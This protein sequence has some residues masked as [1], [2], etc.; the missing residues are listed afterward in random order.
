MEP[1]KSPKKR[2]AFFPFFIFILIFLFDLL[3]GMGHV[4]IKELMF[5]REIILIV[6]ML[7]LV[8]YLKQLK[9][10]NSKDILIKI[11]T[12]FFCVLGV[13]IAYLVFPK[14]APDSLDFYT[15]FGPTQQHFLA[16]IASLLFTAFGIIMLLVLRDMI[17]LRRKK[18]THRNFTLLLL[19]LIGYCGYTLVQYYQ[20]DSNRNSIESLARSGI[21]TGFLALLIMF[22][23]INSFRN[24]WI[25]YLNKRQKIRHLLLSLMLVISWPLFIYQIF[26]FEVMA[27]SL[28]F[29]FFTLQVGLFLVIY[30]SMTFI[31]I[32]FHLP[33]AGIV[34]RKIKEIQS[35]HALSRTISSEFDFERL[36]KKINELSIEVT[37][38]NASW[39]EIIDKTGQLKLVSSK[40]LSPRLVQWIEEHPG[41]GIS[42]LV[43]AHKDALWL[44]DVRKSDSAQYLRNRE[45]N[46]ES[47]MAV[48]VIFFDKILGVLCVLKHQEFGFIPDDLNVLRALTDQ[49]A[50]AL[51]NARLVHENIEKERLAQELKVAHEAQMKLLPKSMPNLKGLD[52]DAICITANDV[53]GDYYD[54]FVFPDNR[55]G[56]VIGDVSGKGA[57]AAFYMAEVKGIIKSL[58]HT[59]NSPREVL[60]RTN[61][62][63]SESLERR[64]FI[65]L[66][67]AVIDL[68]SWKLTFSRAGH[69]PLLFG[70][71]HTQRVEFIEPKGI[72]I[73]LTRG[74]IFSNLL[75]EK[76]L[77][78]NTGD[79][80][81]FFTDG[82]IEAM[83]DRR[84]EFEEA[85]LMAVFRKMT[86][87]DS[88]GIKNQLVA[89]VD[90]FVGGARTHDDLTMIVVKVNRQH[91]PPGTAN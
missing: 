64:Y 82:V 34:D 73:G 43:L 47:L 15:I 56:L 4:R 26:S 21:G 1:K 40:N 67:Y 62:I 10:V 20:A 60:I 31:V 7:L 78:L 35:L 44:N 30:W 46:I 76:E 80:L 86:H 59:Y 45:M 11:R 51:E 77:T 90:A 83:N 13:F 89:E 9:W 85:R 50:V 5:L 66:I 29:E 39:L 75:E 24:S 38:A 23:V 57:E 17:Y 2:F 69:C 3:I 88:R 36:V 71:A 28:V 58:A 27:Y 8:P 61:E 79:A 52:I 68:E 84:E 74:A 63:L 87:L 91:L 53:G 18:S 55:I 32:L 22:M 16:M 19:V 14:M 25:N 65:S 6:G 49:A 54:F 72:G 41:E 48:P 42:Q 81:L 37:E 12:L 33:T 70:Q